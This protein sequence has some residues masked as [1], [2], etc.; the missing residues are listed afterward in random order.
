[1]I[2]PPA[3]GVEAEDAGHRRARTGGEDGIFE[4]QLILVAV[5]FVNMQGVGVDKAGAALYM[6]E[7]TCFDQLAQSP[8]HLGDDLVLPLPQTVQVYLRFG[9]FYTP[10]FGLPRFIE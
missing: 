3:V 4:L 2:P 7:F 5:G 10:L 1:M 6:L 8:G 9:E